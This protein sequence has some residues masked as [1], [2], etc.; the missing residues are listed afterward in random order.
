M[1]HEAELSLLAEDRHRIARELHDGVIQSM[2]GIGLML[3]G[4]KGEKDVR[5]I[6]DQLSGITASINHVIDDLRAYI[7]DLTPT[8]LATHGL[9]AE[10]RSLAQEFQARGGVVASVR[11]RGDVNEIT[12]DQGRHLIQIARESLSNVSR[13]AAAS[14]VTLRLFSGPEGLR[15][16]IVDDGHGFLQDDCTRGRGL[17]N[18]VRRAQVLG[19]TAA[20]ASTGGSGT[21]IRVSVPHKRLKGL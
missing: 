12:A 17:A 4:V 9:E 8:R 3:E 19:G 18:V 2:Y 1:I 6:H 5:R 15:L 16:E 21:A 10:L 7:E 11:V 14:R 13:H 20:I